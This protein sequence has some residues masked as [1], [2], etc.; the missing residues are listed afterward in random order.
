[1]T[2]L[3]SWDGRLFFNN[4]HFAIIMLT[5]RLE[6]RPFIVEDAPQI[7]RLNTDP[8][9]MRHLPKDEVYANV[10]EAR[11]FLDKYISRMQEVP[12]ARQA[13]IRKSDGAWLGWCGL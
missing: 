7:Y 3:I 12:F 13:V 6:I 8:E 9:V 11:F 4:T 10:D 1:M 2:I 5:E